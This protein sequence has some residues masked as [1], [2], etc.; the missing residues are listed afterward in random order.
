MFLNAN[1]D[2]IKRMSS[3]KVADGDVSLC[4][5]MASLL[6]KATGISEEWIIPGSRLVA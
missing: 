6:A 2:T 1:Q 5:A 3:G 4:S